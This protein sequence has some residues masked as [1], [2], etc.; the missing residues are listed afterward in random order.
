MIKFISLS[1]FIVLLTC[2]GA[3]VSEP[4]SSTDF[5]AA[6]SP[7]CNQTYTGQVVS[8]DPQD[9]DWRA[10]VLILGPIS[11]SA[12]GAISMPLAVGDDTSRTWFLT[13]ADQ[14]IEFRHQHLLKNGD[15]DPVSDYGG[16]SDALT[17]EGGEWTV[18]FPAD[19]KT[20]KIF[21][22]NGLEVSVSN[23]WTFEYRE[24]L[25]LNYELNREARYFRAEFDLTEPE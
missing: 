6:L 7:L 16:Y 13:P 18:D 23:V 1:A 24:G 22:D 9:A 12:S 11:C 3:K 17:L 20:V 4:A 14:N 5:L 2:S 15:I 8:D 10:S 19:G 25:A 21:K